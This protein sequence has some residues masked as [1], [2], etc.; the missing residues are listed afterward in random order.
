MEAIV[1]I[2]TVL[3]AIATIFGA[4]ALPARPKHGNLLDLLQFQESFSIFRFQ[5]SHPNRQE[6]VATSRISS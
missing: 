3:L 4:Q 5:M 2:V 1:R 6:Y